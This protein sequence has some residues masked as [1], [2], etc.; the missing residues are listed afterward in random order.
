VLQPV[1]FVVVGC[2]EAGQPLAAARSQMQSYLPMVDRVDLAF[3]QSG[4]FGSI[5]EAD[6]AV[7]T[8]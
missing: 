5:D 8:H 6:R 1:E 4:L 2:R 3:D 7:M